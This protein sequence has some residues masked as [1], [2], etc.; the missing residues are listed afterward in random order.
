MFISSIKYCWYNFKMTTLKRP[1]VVIHDL[2]D[3]SV[4]DI[5]WYVKDK[6]KYFSQAINIGYLVFINY[7][8]CSNILI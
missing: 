8:V 4:M 1:M 3:H 6:H 2:F 5:S 7:I